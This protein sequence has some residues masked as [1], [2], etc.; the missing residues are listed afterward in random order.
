M[1]RVRAR[2]NDLLASKASRTR[3]PVRPSLQLISLLLSS[4]LGPVRRRSIPRPRRVR[5]SL[6]SSRHLI[7]SSLRNRS[8]RNQT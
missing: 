3:R 7:S 1:L 2:N 8:L 6:R 5:L 4:M